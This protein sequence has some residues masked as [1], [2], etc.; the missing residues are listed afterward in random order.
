MQNISDCY[1]KKAQA[2]LSI[3]TVRCNCCFHGIYVLYLCWEPNV[4]QVSLG[5]FPFFSVAGFF[6]FL[7]FFCF[8]KLLESRKGSSRLLREQK[9]RDREVACNMPWVIPWYRESRAGTWL[10]HHQSL[11]AAWSGAERL[12]VV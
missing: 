11:L 9:R 3:D 8:A 7:F 2:Y 1:Y 5:F 4:E 6:S 12:S 10:P